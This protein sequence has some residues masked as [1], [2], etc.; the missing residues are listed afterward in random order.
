MIP[1]QTCNPVNGMIILGA[2]IAIPVL[3]FGLWKDIKKLNNRRA[4]EAAASANDNPIIGGSGPSLLKHSVRDLSKEATRLNR[5]LKP[6]LQ[7][8]AVIA[9]RY[10]EVRQA[11]HL[12]QAFGKA[13]VWPSTVA[14]CEVAVVEKQPTVLQR[15]STALAITKLSGKEV[16]R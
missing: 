4:D 8:P 1:G 14:G 6:G 2:L 13:A 5:L 3:F 9:E 10:H 12:K 11:L 15:V 7:E 16:R